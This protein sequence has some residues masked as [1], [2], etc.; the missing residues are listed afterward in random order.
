VWCVGRGI[1][2]TEFTR[3]QHRFSL[4]HVFAG[5]IDPANVVA[6]YMRRRRD[7]CT[8]VKF[9]RR[10]KNH[11]TIPRKKHDATSLTQPKCPRFLY[12]ETTIWHCTYGISE[13]RCHTKVWR[14]CFGVSQRIYLEV[15]KTTRHTHAARWQSASERF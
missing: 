3:D 10:T 2:E 7:S 5:Y 9:F 4:L 13:I 6:E 1:Q 8:N 12:I 11:K 14:M 15:F